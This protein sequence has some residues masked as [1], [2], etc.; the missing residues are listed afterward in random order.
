MERN[1]CCVQMTDQPNIVAISTLRN[2]LET[3]IFGIS[4]R[5][6]RSAEEAVQTFDRSANATGVLGVEVQLIIDGV[7]ALS[8]PGP[9]GQPICSGRGNCVNGKCVCN[10]G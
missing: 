6:N 5:D 1:V 9:V 3:C 10:T 2:F 4:R 8:C 7:V